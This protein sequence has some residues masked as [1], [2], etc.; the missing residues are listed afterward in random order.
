MLSASVGM[1]DGHCEFCSAV[2]ASEPQQVGPHSM[3]MEGS[4]M[5]KGGPEGPQQPCPSLS[6]FLALGV[7]LDVRGRV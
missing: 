6:P 1:W 2:G 7:H 3:N 4:M 5:Y